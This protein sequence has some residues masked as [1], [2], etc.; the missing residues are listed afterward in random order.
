MKRR[1]LTTFLLCVS[2]LSLTFAQRAIT[3]KVTDDKGESLLGASVVVKGTTTGTITDADGSYSL[4]VPNAGAVLIFSFTGFN[5]KEVEVGT[6]NTLDVTLSEGVLLGEVI[7]T[8]L[9]TKRDKR[10]AG[11]SAQQVTN[12]DLKMGQSS[13]PLNALVGKVAGANITTLSGGPGSST[14]VVLRGGSSI[15][16]NNQ[17]LIVVDGIPI[18]NT[19]ILSSG[20][21]L[22]NQVDFGNRGND[23]NPNDVES[24]TVLKGPSAAA[25]FGSRASN[26]ALLI[27]TKRGKKGQA[28]ITLNSNNYLSSI[29]KLPD[30]QTQF[31]QG[32]LLGVVDDRRENFSWG[33]PFDG[34][35]RPWGQEIDGQQ[36]VK[37]YVALPNYMRDFFD[38]GFTSEND[39]SFE[40]GNDKTR[41]R[42]SA[43][44]LN[45][46]GIIPTTTFNKYNLRAN[47]DAEVTSYLSVSVS[48]N[49]NTISSDLASGGQG[50]GSIYNNVI[51]TPVDIPIR[52]GRDLNNPYNRYDQAK[53]Q[54]GFYG[55]YTTNPYFLLENFK[56]E[57][58][59]DRIGG[60]FSIVLKPTSWL[61]ITERIGL[62][63]YSDRRF[64]KELKY[65]FQP[66]DPFFAVG[67]RTYQGNY[68]ESNN[69]LNEINNDLFAS[70]NSNINDKLG[71]NATIGTNLRSRSL[72]TLTSSVNVQGGLVIPDF[73]NLD[74]SNGP[75]VSANTLNLRRT[76]SVFGDVTLS[77]NNLLFLGGTVRNDWSST[78]PKA[79]N[80]YFY[81]SVNASFVFSDLLGENVRNVLSFGKLR[82]SWANVGNDAN[83]YLL[84]NVFTLPNITTG[85]GSTIFPF[86]KSDGSTVNGFQQ[87]AVLAN[88]SLK[89]ENV[90]EI[91]LGF[92]LAFWQERLSVDLAW[93]KRT[94]TDQIIPAVPISDATGFQF[95]TLNAGKLV[96]DGIELTLRGY[97]VLTKNF[98]WELFGTYNKFKNVVEYIDQNKKPEDD[99][100][101]LGGFG[102]MS[103]VAA[104]GRPYGT[105]YT[106]DFERDSAS[107]KVL[108][109][110]SGLPKTAS[111]QSYL[112]SYLPDY[113][114]SFGSNVRFKGLRLGFVFDTKQGGVFYS[115]TRN[116]MQFV[117]T[118]K[119]TAINN[120]ETFVIENSVVKNADGTVSPNTVG[121]DVRSYFNIANNTPALALVDGS[122]VKLREATLSYTFPSDML[123]KTFFKEV[124]VGLFGN[125]LFLWTP[126]SNQYADPEINSNGTGNTQG[127]DFTA[128]P[129]QR[130]Y[131]FNVK[132][133]F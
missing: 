68:T 126:E 118:S 18:D 1:I 103:V 7:T 92:D 120:R 30:V 98:S 47:I 87:N 93:Y 127:F 56:N 108:V 58:S 6:S 3:G 95:V 99:Q 89:P 36:R 113:I 110:S 84:S 46:K 105:F 63:A 14:R 116:T 73:Y 117:G 32:D 86:I 131:G 119:E 17:A 77:Y 21:I 111:S 132:V 80:S 64:R 20:N 61:S 82:A 91:E 42:I 70:I 78:L 11:Y 74:N 57:N 107:G 8:A 2:L 97:P 55:A 29:L 102:G 44:S 59:V 69:I 125:N 109:N 62:D 41:Y 15:T 52:E 12:E 123:G 106:A 60:N 22:N 72:R 50:N 27:T 5:T 26:G 112:G 48:A 43:N 37:P 39:L 101:V 23:V 104:A 51:Q 19:N 65:D 49:Y 53:G 100:I 115:R 71:I 33:L 128:Q 35:L 94:S 9:G 10:S 122:F 66:I 25:L 40:G 75:S 24:I 129:S 88:Q 121:A 124:T 28:K 54:Y 79:N 114:A 85:F 16:G 130:N 76:Y 81:P 31:G 96:N 90:E 67:N 4:S 133:S 13:S 45:S 34:Q 38:T 83:P